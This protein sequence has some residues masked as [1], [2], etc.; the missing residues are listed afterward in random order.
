MEG[1][2]HLFDNY[3][4]SPRFFFTATQGTSGK[5]TCL[6]KSALFVPKPHHV[7]FA[8]AG[9][10]RKLNSETKENEPVPCVLYEEAQEIFSGNNLESPIYSLLSTYKRGPSRPIVI[11]DKV[12][13]QRM[14]Y[15]VMMDGLINKY[16]I[17][18]NFLE[19]CVQVNMLKKKKDELVEEFEQ[20]DLE[21]EIGD[22]LRKTRQKW[23]KAITREAIKNIHN[24]AKQDLKRLGAE[25]RDRECLIPLVE[26]A[27]FCGA[28]IYDQALAAADWYLNNKLATMLKLTIDQQLL[29]DI[30]DICND[31]KLEPKPVNMLSSDLRDALRAIDDAPW[32]TFGSSAKG[33]NTTNIAALLSD[34]GIRSYK[35]TNGNKRYAFKHFVD[36]W[37][38]VLNKP[39]PEHLR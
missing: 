20:M 4:Y 24:Q 26:Y 2:M 15:P 27:W 6:L 31:S 14:F 10:L 34:Y 22:E 3:S 36:V 13:E 11:D 32:S 25:N 39:T 29:A 33:L 35:D 1:H 37:E 21:E 18:P 5:T 28:D 8:G 38:R 19:R 12:F 30:Y 17:P 7:T 23:S 16:S 9:L